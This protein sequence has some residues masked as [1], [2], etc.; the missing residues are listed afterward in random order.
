MEKYGTAGRVTDDNITS[1]MRFACWLTKDTD[2]QSE[3][4]ILITF[5]PQTR[6]GERTLL[7]CY[8]YIVCLVLFVRT[9]WLLTFM[10]YF[11]K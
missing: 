8:T 10:V 1:R 3:Y 5:P 7:L 4:V 11:Y 9:V 6:L 2:T